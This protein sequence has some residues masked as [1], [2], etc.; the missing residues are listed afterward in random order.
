MGERNMVLNMQDNNDDADNKLY[1]TMVCPQINALGGENLFKSDG[2]NL[3]SYWM[4]TEW[5]F[6]Y[7]GNISEQTN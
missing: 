4:N 5:M 1:V 6:L 3:V 7:K 2:Q